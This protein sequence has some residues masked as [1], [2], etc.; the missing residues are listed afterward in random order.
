MYFE[1]KITL[2][3]GRIKMKKIITLI[4]L[5]TLLVTSLVGC[6]EPTT[7]ETSSEKCTSIGTGMS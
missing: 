6:G 7:S 1:S 4:V 2:R 5:T 3:K